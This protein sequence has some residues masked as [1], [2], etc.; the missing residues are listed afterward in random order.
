MFSATPTALSK[1]DWPVLLLAT[2]PLQYT[3]HDLRVMVGGCR[4]TRMGFPFTRTVTVFF[5]FLSLRGISALLFSWR[6]ETPRLA[7]QRGAS[8][9]RVFSQVSM[10]DL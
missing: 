1:S 10:R 7:S 9:Q 3:Y 4:T 2:K 8:N 6:N 5:S